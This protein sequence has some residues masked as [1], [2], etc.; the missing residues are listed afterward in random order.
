MGSTRSGLGKLLLLVYPLLDVSSLAVLVP[1]SLLRREVLKTVGVFAAVFF[2]FSLLSAPASDA[3]AASLAL[4]K[5]L[6]AL[7]LFF[8]LLEPGEVAWFLEKLGAR[9]ASAY[10]L[11]ISLR[12]ADVVSRE[13]RA[14]TAAQRAKGAGGV[15]AILKSGLP[16]VVYSMEYA[17]YLAVQ[18]G[19]RNFRCLS[20]KPPLFTKLDAVIASATAAAV[21]MHWAWGT[22]AT[23]LAGAV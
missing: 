5:N 4:F 16:L 1:L 17:E 18:L 10:I 8:R 2:L 13:V 19:Q 7:G 9:G 20:E 6:L 23:P 3:A 12:A 22:L 14:F 15:A 21:A 11:V